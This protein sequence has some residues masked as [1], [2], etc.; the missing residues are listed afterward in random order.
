MKTS[1]S[2]VIVI[3]RLLGTLG[4]I[5]SLLTFCTN[6]WLLATETCTQSENITGV[7]FKQRA[8]I[9]LKQNPTPIL[10]QV[11]DVP[12]NRSEHDG[13]PKGHIQKRSIAETMKK[14]KHFPGSYNLF[15]KVSG[16][17]FHYEGFFWSC[18][19]DVRHVEDSFST[20]MFFEQAPSKSCIEAY[21][22]PF[23]TRLNLNSSAYDSAAGFRH[24]WSVLIVFSVFSIGIGFGLI[25]YEA[26]KGRD[27]LY[28]LGGGFFVLAGI[29]STFSII[30][31]SFWIQA[32]VAVVDQ[33][34]EPP[35]SCPHP[36]LKVQ[37]G[38]S[39]MAAPVGIVFSLL[40]GLLFIH[41][42]CVA[43]NKKKNLEYSLPLDKIGNEDL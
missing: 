33:I 34:A 38:W 5:F 39:F 32:L 9:A 23:P 11:S 4:V 10:K 18:T 42:G 37:F 31:Y 24:S 15:N 19:M 25:V 41:F 43:Q 36:N 21:H 7:D 35:K 30:M 8:Q 12:H 40:A 26:F 17:T 29:L 28:L 1:T 20:Y 13:P 14:I 3:A 2:K 27:T 16:K 22:L 6:C